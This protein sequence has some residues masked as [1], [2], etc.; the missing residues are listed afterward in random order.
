MAKLFDSP[1]ISWPRGSQ[2]P[3]ELGCDTL[4]ISASLV[5]VIVIDPPEHI[6]GMRYSDSLGKCCNIQ[7]IT[8]LISPDDQVTL[9]TQR[10]VWGGHAKYLPARQRHFNYFERHLPDELAETSF[11]VAKLPQD[12]FPGRDPVSDPS[13]GSF[14]RLQDRVETRGQVRQHVVMVAGGAV[15][16]P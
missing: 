5:R 14:D 6:G 13:V 10:L 2:L 8:Y 1:G 11:D 3:G 4:R 16:G 9:D 15:I 7:V 12:D